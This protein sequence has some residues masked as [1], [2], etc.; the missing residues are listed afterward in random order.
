MNAEVAE[1]L[2]R[3]FLAESLD[4]TGE[5]EAAVLALEDAPG[6]AELLGRLFRAVHTLKGNAAM[7]GADDVERLTHDLETVLDRAR[8][9]RLAADGALIDLVLETRDLVLVMLGAADGEV[10]PAQVDRLTATFARLAGAPGGAVAPVDAPAAA[11]KTRWQVAFRPGPGLFRSGQEPLLVLK[12]LS[13][14][15]PCEVRLDA[16]RLPELEAL[17]PETCYVG[18]EAEVVAEGGEDA[19]RE[20]FMFVEDDAEIRIAPAPARAPASGGGAGREAAPAGAA[21]SELRVASEKLDALIDLVGELVTLQARLARRAGQ[22]ADPELRDVSEHLE[23]LT[24][25]LR[26]SAFAV[27]MVPVGQTFA[28]F[29][30]LVRDLC[31]ELGREADLVLEGGETEIDKGLVG[32]LH[33][34][35]VHLVRNAMDH[36]LEPPEAREAAGKP[37]RGTV[38]LSAAQEGS[39]VI[40][41]VQDDGRGLDLAAVRARAVERGLLAEDE[42]AS[43]DRLADLVFAP[44]F[45][46]ARAVS[47]V[48]GRG[49]GL[50]AVRR[51]IEALRGTVSLANAA[52]GG[53]VATVRLPLTLAIVEGLLVAVGDERYVVPVDTV[54]ACVEV[55]PEETGGD[56]QVVAW[57]G[58]LVPFVRLRE[59]FAV[60][61]PPALREHLVVLD[62][63]GRSV[64]LVVDDVVG[65]QQTV[66]K[67]LGKVYAHVEGLAGATLL[68]DGRVALVLDP[69]A[70]ARA[71]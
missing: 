42:E 66:I 53:T 19:V 67:P 36:G 2:R 61:A 17:E 56:E 20:A 40:V 71:R 64:A 41:R 50:D 7:F 43:D 30:R 32:H 48:S 70:I 21:P 1:R 38:R 8:E 16:S 65:K 9:G 22:D 55:G 28:R 63:G 11:A 54:D 5:I 49:V 60:S 46:T 33:E 68:G 59:L 10:D 44:G 6:D 37:R 13:E 39:E 27:R 4:L 35:L 52:G 26:D 62:A 15:G 51:S 57:R 45:S 12:E 47:A 14:L 25:E 23:R 31:G 58:A 29:R 3:S 24:W 34:A 69:A 18:W